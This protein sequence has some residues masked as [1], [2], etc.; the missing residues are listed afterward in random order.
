MKEKAARQ[1]KRVASGSWKWQ[2][3]DLQEGTR[4]LDLWTAI[5]LPMLQYN[6]FVS[7]YTT[8]FVA[9]FVTVA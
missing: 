2:E 8:N 5:R 4:S 3:R 7:G 9:V 6:K 1:E